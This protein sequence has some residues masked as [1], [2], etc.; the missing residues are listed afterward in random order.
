LKIEKILCP[1]DFSD[2]AYQALSV[3]LDLAGDYSAELLLSHVVEYLPPLL[4]G[5]KDPV[6]QFQ[7][8][9]QQMESDAGERLQQMVKQLM[10]G[11]TKVKTL[12]KIGH[13][14]FQISEWAENYGVD[15]IV[16]ASHG[17][18][19]WRQAFLGSV[20]ARI[21][22]LTKRPVWVIHPQSSTRSSAGRHSWN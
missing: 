3:A 18:T 15:L 10:V 7:K 6:S 19:G 16:I 9:C 20:T 22:V 17:L 12:I 21:L 8:C 11:Q 13:P 2:P 4:S 1:T 5:G 14:A